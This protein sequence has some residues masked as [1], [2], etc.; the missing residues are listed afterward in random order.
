MWLLLEPLLKEGE[1][2]GLLYCILTTMKQSK[3]TRE[4]DNI[5]AECWVKGGRTGGRGGGAGGRGL[6]MSDG[7]EDW[8]ERLSGW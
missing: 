8:W 6:V 1:S 3:E 4:P 2:H 7:W 5:G